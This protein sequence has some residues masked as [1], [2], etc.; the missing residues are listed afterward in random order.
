[1]ETKNQ[2]EQ[3]P[4]QK[5]PT[6]YHAIVFLVY[7]FLFQHLLIVQITA[8]MVWI[9]FVA[10]VYGNMFSVVN[11]MCDGYS[12]YYHFIGIYVEY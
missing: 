1:M 3:Q 8:G 6:M 9:K 4:P 7:L 5:K 10:N 11:A 12:F 2:D